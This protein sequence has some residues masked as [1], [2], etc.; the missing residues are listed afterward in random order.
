MR[1][2]PPLTIVNILKQIVYLVQTGL[3]FEG[4]QKQVLETRFP[5]LEYPYPGLAAI[6]KSQGSRLI[7]THLPISFLPKSA[8][9]NGTKVDSPYQLFNHMY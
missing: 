7:K 8:T 1:I 9:L 2:L 6:K 3:D 5:Y 4:A